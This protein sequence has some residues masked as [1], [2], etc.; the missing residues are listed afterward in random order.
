VSAGTPHNAGPRRHPDSAF[1]KVGDEGGLVVLP[2]RAEVKVLNPVGIVVFSL[3]DGTHGVD[4][5]AARV[6]DEFEIDEA[7]ARADVVSF[8]DELR[9]AGMLAETA[10]ASGTR[11]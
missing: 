11:S 10:E 4:D 7:A 9:Q 8:L 1:R 5:L 3:L 2:G 6:A